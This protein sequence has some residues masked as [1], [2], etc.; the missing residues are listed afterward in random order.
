MLAAARIWAVYHYFHPYLNL[1]DE[2][3]DRVLVRY[4]EK[5]GNAST[6][7]AYHLAVAEM[8][9]L[10]RD[11]HCG[12]YSGT[13]NN[14]LGATIPLVE[15][16]WIEN[17]V[18]VTRVLA[19]ALQPL[20]RPGDVILGVDGQSVQQRL[21]DLTP[22]L[23]ASTPQSL[24]EKAMTYFLAGA[25]GSTARLDVQSPDGAVRSV[26]ATRSN[27]LSAILPYRTGD[28]YRLLDTR[29]GYVDLERLTTAQ[30][31]AMFEL[32][33][34]TDAIVMDMR[35]YPQATAWSIAPRLTDVNTPVAAVFR[36]NVV[37]GMPENGSFL[38]TYLFEQQLPATNLWRYHG[39]T[40]M[41]TDARAISQSEHSGL[42]YRAANG[43]KF[44][45]SGTTGANGDVTYFYAPGNIQIVF[46]GH[47]VRWLDGSRL[48]RVGLIPDIFVEPT[49]RGVAEG[50]DEVLDRALEYLRSGR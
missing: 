18:V 16:R 38:S 29:T 13:I 50:R 25:F 10:T 35:G 43:T 24:M 9:A 26:S 20:L 23:A 14:Y 33:R 1:Y 28:V 30:V 6:A 7:L 41:L 31:N 22:Y 49:I 32:F 15:V 11:S 2:D 19:A 48:Q 3:W 21:A 27:S 47:D 4:L 34:N 37:S 44:I 36:R 17:R 40:V 5:M 45:G 39:K 12:A 8:V 46:T 42:F